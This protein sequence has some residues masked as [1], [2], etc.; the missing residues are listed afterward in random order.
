MKVLLLHPED[1]LL[2]KQSQGWDLIVDLGRAPAATYELWSRQ[3][4]CRIVSLY[5]YG[6]G[7][8]DL[9]RFKQTIHQG[10]DFVIDKRGIDWWDVVLPMLLPDMECCYM[11][12]GLAKELDGSTKLYCGRPDPHAR[13]LQK[14]LGVECQILE[15]GPSAFTRK[16]RHYKEAFSH[17][18]FG[19][20]TQIVQDKFDPEHS[21]RRRLASKKPATG[22]RIFLLPTAY[23]NVS[24]TA[25]AYA[26]LLPEEQFL[27]AVARPGGRLASLP[28][29]VRMISLDAY[30]ERS[31]TAELTG[32]IE[33]WEKLQSR[34]D[35][36]EFRMASALGVLQRGCGLIRWGVA[37][38]NAWIRLFESENIAGC[39]SADDVNPYTSLPLFIA[40]QRNI[41]ALA[42]HH[43][44]IDSRMSVK[45][46]IADFYLAKGELE[47]DYLLD[48]C[49]ADP[50]RIVMAGPRQIFPGPAASTERPWL[51]FFS[52]P[53]AS[54]G[55][56]MD[57]VYKDLLPPLCAL[58]RQCGLKLVFKLHPFESIKGHRNLL[59][60]LLPQDQLAEIHWIVGPSTAELWSKIRFAMSVESTIALECASREIP[61]FLCGWL[62]NGYG[63]YIRQYAKFGVGH[64]LNSPNEMQNVPQL[65][66]TWK[67]C[68][69]AADGKIWQMVE[70]ADLRNLLT[71]N[72]RRKSTMPAQIGK[73]QS[74]SF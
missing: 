25:V 39:L 5:Q 57:E 67:K 3:A 55:W 56:R 21:V 16:V 13:A 53:Y 66:A 46:L 6:R 17:L 15:G 37:A 30:F 47:R 59:R 18:D 73:P 19:Q 14:F 64:I 11:L 72:Y 58:A 74:N 51:V 29:N 52:E 12:L 41:P 26:A 35:S 23:I 40:T 7:F 32:L 44:A 54:A 10:K 63:G 69:A 4:N 71:G 27:L 31:D 65:L 22:K 9:Y 62:Q 33:K 42:V 45:P 60:K 49:R 38:R 36:P 28:S 61:I 24:R 8:E 70:P 2:P 48:T 20:L 50:E 68:E 1:R 43:G 34:L